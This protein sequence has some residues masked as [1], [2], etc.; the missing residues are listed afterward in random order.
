M[1]HTNKMRVPDPGK[2]SRSFVSHSLQTLSHSP[3]A[4]DT[5]KM[6]KNTENVLKT[7]GISLL[8]PCKGSPLPLRKEMIDKW[9]DSQSQNQAR[10]VRGIECKV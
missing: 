8:I 3:T 2:E 7:N 9:G 5:H 1:N 6:L 4:K 10:H